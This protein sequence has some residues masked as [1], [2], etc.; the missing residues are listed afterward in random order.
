MRSGGNKTV[1]VSVMRTAQATLG[2]A[3]PFAHELLRTLALAAT[4]PNAAGGAPPPPL[5]PSDGALARAATPPLASVLANSEL[6][7]ELFEWMPDEDS[8][9]G[10]VAAGSMAP[11]HSSL[12]VLLHTVRVLLET[13]AREFAEDTLTLRALHSVLNV[14]DAFVALLRRAHVMIV[15]APPPSGEEKDMTGDAPSQ[16]PAAEDDTGVVAAATRML[17]TEAVT[18]DLLHAR[19]KAL[20]TFDEVLYY[21]YL[22]SLCVFSSF[23]THRRPL[24]WM[25]ALVNC[26]ALEHVRCY[27]TFY[28]TSAKIDAAALRALTDRLQRGYD[29][30]P[31]R[32]MHGAFRDVAALPDVQWLFALRSSEMFL[33]LWRDAAH[34][35]CVETVAARTAALA[36]EAEEGSDGDDVS[37][38]DEESDGEGDGDAEGEGG[39][40]GEDGE[41][42]EER[43][44]REAQRAERQARRAAREARREAR[45][46]ARR[47]VAQ[48]R[49]AAA[50]EVLL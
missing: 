11:L 17:A 35:L 2:V 9:G 42:E 50:L 19:R 5:P 23:M 38:E 43:A 32:A 21:Q 33:R 15:V 25:T 8:V 6:W 14:D 45:R 41:G 7:C 27:A 37:G 48:D 34:V 24:S 47:F 29:A 16:A 4:W 12:R 22:L 31:S 18:P 40:G 39:E 36:V 26:K 46:D 49:R 3:S 30:M 13:T 1:A 28:C 44:A 20:R 10:E